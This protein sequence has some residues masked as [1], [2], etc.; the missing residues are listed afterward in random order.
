MTMLSFSITTMSFNLI[1]N[2]IALMVLE[3]PHEDDQEEIEYQEDLE[4]E[5]VSINE[6]P[7]FSRIDSNTH[8]ICNFCKKIASYHDMENKKYCWF[9]R[10]QYE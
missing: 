7:I 8:T 6:H 2:Q 4:N 9:H 5:K 1:N 3:V 10:S